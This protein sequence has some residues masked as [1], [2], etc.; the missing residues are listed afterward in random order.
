MRL[1]KRREF[2]TCDDGKGTVFHLT[3]FKTQEI[4]KAFNGKV[5]VRR[6]S[7]NLPVEGDEAIDRLRYDKGM[8]TFE[9]EV[10]SVAITDIS[11]SLVILEFLM[12]AVPAAEPEE[13]LSKQR[14]VVEGRSTVAGVLLYSD[15]PQAILPKRSAVKIL[16]YR[17]KAGGER[18]YLAFEPLTIEGPI[19]SLIYDSVAKCKEIVE[20]IRKLGP[21]GL[22]QV[23][24]PEEALREVLTN[25]VLHRDYSIAADVQVRIFDNRIEIESPGKLPGHVT[26]QNI[27][28]TQF[29]RN[30]KL[31]RLVNK[32]KEPPNKESL[33]RRVELPKY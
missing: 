9:D 2:L 29:A 18:D 15:D 21:N 20:G 7:Q 12:S 13:W 28:K 1:K 23:A 17:T 10:S 27:M 19:Y 30:P 31:V 8:K 3:V 6:G 22:E 14:V 5:Y 4:I 16:Q 32:F 24:Y 26:I 25:A 11:N 33:Y